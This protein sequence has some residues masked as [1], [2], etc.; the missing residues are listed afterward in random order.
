MRIPKLKPFLKSLTPLQLGILG[1]L[2]VLTCLAWGGMTY[3]MISKT[4]QI[5]GPLI[6]LGPSGP[7]AIPT[8]TPTPHPSPTPTPLPLRADEGWAVY[9]ELLGYLQE[10]NAGGVDTL[11]KNPTDWRNCIKERSEEECL[12]TLHT[13]LYSTEAS[14]L[15][16]FTTV[17]SDDKQIVMLSDPVPRTQME[18][19]RV[20]MTYS[21]VTLYFARNLAGKIKVLPTQKRTWSTVGTAGSEQELEEKLQEMMRDSDQDGLTDEDEMCELLDPSCSPTDAQ[22]RD[23]DG[24]GYWDGTEVVAGTDPTSKASN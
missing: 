13:D 4:G 21:R 24:D 1:G 5:I 9:Q 11:L 14:E 20:S 15:E 19:D 3:V 2:T 12:D 10:N 7:T 16:D 22:S 18:D 23:T 8:W 17:W 6:G